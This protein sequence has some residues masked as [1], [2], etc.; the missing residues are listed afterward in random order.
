VTVRASLEGRWLKVEVEDYGRWRA[1]RPAEYRGYGIPTMRALTRRVEIDRK[2][3]GTAVRFTVSL[4]PE[5]AE[6]LVQP[7]PLPPAG[8]TAPGSRPVPDGGTPPRTGADAVVMAGA[9]PFVPAAGAGEYSPASGNGS[10]GNGSQG[11]GFR[12]RRSET[13]V[14]IVELPEEVDLGTIHSLRSVLEEAARSDRRAVVVS[15][16]GVAFFDSHAMHTLL[17]FNRRLE[18]NRQRL[19]AVVPAGHPL[20]VVLHVLEVAPNVAVADTLTEAVEAAQGT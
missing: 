10:Q 13:G 1:P 9:M 20:K 4:S 14:P 12:V 19:V 8:D 3:T 17:R 16:D 5:P 15:F 6:R 7:R 2:A 11:D 18:M